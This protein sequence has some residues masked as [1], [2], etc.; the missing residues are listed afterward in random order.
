MKLS[1]PG[2]ATFILRPTVTAA[3]V[4]FGVCSTWYLWILATAQYPAIGST[5]PFRLITTTHFAVLSAIH[6]AFLIAFAVDG[7]SCKRSPPAMRRAHF[8]G[9]L[10]AAF[11][12]VLVQLVAVY[13]HGPIPLE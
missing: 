5:E 7:Y 6:V 1:A 11:T 3:I 9:L 2:N 8:A 12:L 13:A 4:Y 10:L